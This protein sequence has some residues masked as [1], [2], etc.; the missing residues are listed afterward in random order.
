MYHLPRLVIA[1]ILL[2]SFTT[3]VS[4]EPI[5]IEADRA[6]FD[7][8]SGTTVFEGDVRLRR[9]TL[10]INADKI[11]IYR[12]NNRLDRTVA[13][14]KPAHY[15]QQLPQGG[16]TRAEAHKI[17]YFATTE[18]LHMTGQASLQHDKNRFSGE[19]IIYYIR[20]DKIQA[21][22]SKT[23]KQRVRAVIY[24]DENPQQ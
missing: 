14:G 11:T 18:E 1:C 9:G 2:C 5:D 10:F 12:I 13:E 16:E 4:G 17:E 24:P 15:S 8:P 21:G 3:A 22:S 23:D 19:H 7:D 6:E 20:S